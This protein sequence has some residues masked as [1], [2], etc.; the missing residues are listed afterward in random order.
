[1]KAYTPQPQT[2]NGQHQPNGGAP[3]GGTPPR[4]VVL[5]MNAMHQEEE[6]QV[7]E[8]TKALKKL[9]NVERID[10]APDYGR[11]FTMKREEEEKK[12]SKNGKSV[13][14]APIGSGMIG[15][16]APLAQIAKVK[17]VRFV[18]RKSQVFQILYFE[19]SHIFFGI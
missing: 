14:I 2:P 10:E 7:D 12:K 11:K 3:N 13:P 18:A 17:D 4:G 9:V 8:M 6:E 15:Q 5:S 16:N 19:F 1:M